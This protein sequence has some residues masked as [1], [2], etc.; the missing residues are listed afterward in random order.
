[1][2]TITT[3]LK[4]TIY[5]CLSDILTVVL[6]EAAKDTDMS[7]LQQKLQE[8]QEIA[9]FLQFLDTA[10]DTDLIV[11]VSGTAGSSFSRADRMLLAQP[12]P[13]PAP[14]EA[15]L[16]KNELPLHLQSVVTP[17]AITQEQVYHSLQDIPSAKE[18]EKLLWKAGEYAPDIKTPKAGMLP[19]RGR[20]L[21]VPG[22]GGITAEAF[23]ARG[24][25]S[26]AAFVHAK[27]PWATSCTSID[28]DLYL[29]ENK[30]DGTMHRQRIRRAAE[31]AGVTPSTPKTEEDPLLA[32]LQG[33]VEYISDKDIAVYVKEHSCTREQMF[34]QRYSWNV[35][36]AKTE[37]GYYLFERASDRY[38]VIGRIRQAK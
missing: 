17:T 30:M 27:A 12:E 20:C 4:T 37:T 26:K 23:V 33:K 19:L 13:A 25:R 31:A 11:S 32:G 1:M 2:F 15:P 8:A 5:S 7:A 21:K 9:P 22:Y 18:E 3:S 14:V 38:E 28:N 16:P 34:Q 36:W 24:Y 10:G 6:Q 29:W 35:G